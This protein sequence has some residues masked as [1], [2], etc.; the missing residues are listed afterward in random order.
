MCEP[1]CEFGTCTDHNECTCI[2]GYTGPACN[3][4]GE[5]TRKHTSAQAFTSHTP[6]Q[7]TC[8]CIWAHKHT[9]MHTCMY[10]HESISCNVVHIYNQGCWKEGWRCIQGNNYKSV[11]LISIYYFCKPYEIKCRSLVIV[12]L[13]LYILSVLQLSLPSGVSVARPII[14][15]YSRFRDIYSASCN[16]PH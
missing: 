7:V 15:F 13:H 11:L 2:Y 14:A 9:H 10:A 6:T 1:P 16:L 8:T 3:Q 4:T 12:H 5:Y